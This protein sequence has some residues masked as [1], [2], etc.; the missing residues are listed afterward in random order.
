[1]NRGLIVG[2]GVGVVALFIL[3]IISPMAIQS[4]KESW[5]KNQEVEKRILEETHQRLEKESQST[6]EVETIQPQILTPPPKQTSPDTTTPSKADQC[7]DPDSYCMKKYGMS[8]LKGY[9]TCLEN[10]I[11]SC[12]QGSLND[13]DIKVL[14]VKKLESANSDVLMF[15]LSFVNNGNVFAD[16]PLYWFYLIDSKSREFD[17]ISHNSLREKGIQVSSNDCPA[18]YSVDVNPSLSTLQKIC[19]EVPKDIGES[20]FLKLYENIPII[21]E[22]PFQSCT[23]LKF[24]YTIVWN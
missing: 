14:N 21:C 11:S 10:L 19:Y 7:S 23:I 15:E 3:I 1:M 5:E 9:N 20:I 18:I 22:N 12:E 17:S 13:I 4:I 16:I 2:I 8:N 6:S 24:P